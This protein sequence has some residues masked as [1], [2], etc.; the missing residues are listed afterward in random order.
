[1]PSESLANDIT[2]G[3]KDLD[4]TIKPV[5]TFT[6]GTHAALK[7]LKQFVARGL[8]D[9]VDKRNHPEVKG[10]SRLSPYLHFG[11]IGP[12][13]IALAVERALAKGQ[14]SAGGARSL[15]RTG[16]RLARAFGFVR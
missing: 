11:N 15:P 14:D 9:Y 10:T 5:D 4:R 12:I 8:K 16:D 6:G 7:G 2:A 3:F 1:M 13:T